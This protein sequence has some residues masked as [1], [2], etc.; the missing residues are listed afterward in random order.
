MQKMVD[1]GAIGHV[2]N[3]YIQVASVAVLQK[4]VSQ[5]G[6]SAWATLS[7]GYAFCS[8]N[9]KFVKKQGRTIA[10]TRAINQ[11]QSPHCEVF[12]EMWNENNKGATDEQV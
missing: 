3:N 6:L 7:T 8:W 11:V 1:V 4:R 12:A 5:D 9:D 2:S 10:F